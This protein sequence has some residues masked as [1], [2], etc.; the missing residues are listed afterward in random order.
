MWKIISKPIQYTVTV[1]GGNDGK[2]IKE[3]YSLSS[4]CCK[5]SGVY[6][7]MWNVDS[8]REE[9]HLYHQQHHDRSISMSLYL[10]NLSLIFIRFHHFQAP[11]LFVFFVRCCRCRRHHQLYRYSLC[12]VLY[13]LKPIGYTLQFS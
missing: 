1:N 7:K 5:K 4:F 2:D 10:I 13:T 6:R 8:T 9:H 3:I 11:F 12:A